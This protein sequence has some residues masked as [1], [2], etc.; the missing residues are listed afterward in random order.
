VSNQY[1]R[2]KWDLNYNLGQDVF[3]I[4]VKNPDMTFADIGKRLGYAP[5][6]VG[7]AVKDYVRKL[8]EKEK[9]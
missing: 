2:S 1:G 7:Q 4:M 5:T 8:I 9:E 6:R 3:N